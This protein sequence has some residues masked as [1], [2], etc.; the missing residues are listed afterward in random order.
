MKYKKLRKELQ[1]SADEAWSIIEEK[2]NICIIPHKNPD[3]DALGASTGLAILLEKLGKTVNIVSPNDFPEFLQ[4]LPGNDKITIWFKH[5]YKAEAIIKK[6]DLIIFLDFNNLERIGDMEKLVSSLPIKKIMIDH[7]PYPENIAD[8]IIS[9]TL[10]SSTSELVTHFIVFNRKLDLL[11]SDSASSL[12]TGIITDTG[13][14]SYNSSQPETYEALKV[15]LSKNVDKDDIYNKV[16]NNYSFD[17]MR[18]MGYALN[19]KMVYLPDYKMAYIYL[20]KEELKKYNFVSG[21]SENFVNLPLSIKGVVF[22]ALLLEKDDRIKM[23][24]RSK[25]TFPANK[26]A[27]EYFNGGGHLNAAGGHFFGSMQETI[28]EMNKALK[29]YKETLNNV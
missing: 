8:V 16:F 21:D 3:G 27:S 7:H 1:K 25:K 14:F 12:L 19:E 20:T 24:F 4:W 2:H 26:F 23:S 9:D 18:L 5:K 11:D 29:K 22:S 10:S 13:S 6:S 17:R 28:D 15:L